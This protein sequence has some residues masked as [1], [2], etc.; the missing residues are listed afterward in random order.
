MFQACVCIFCFYWYTG[1]VCI[2]G[3]TAGKKKKKKTD[4]PYFSVARYANTTNLFLPNM[5]AE[6]Q[7]GVSAVQQRSV[8]NQKGT[9]TIDF[10]Q[11]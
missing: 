8:E 4:L 10:I 1:Y 5:M 2:N 7:K 9:I 6:S 11:R 3:H